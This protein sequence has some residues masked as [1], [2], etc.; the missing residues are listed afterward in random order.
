MAGSAP[1]ALGGPAF[2]PAPWHLQGYGLQLVFLTPMKL[3]RALV[4]AQLEPRAVLPGYSLGA[5]SVGHYDER[6]TLPYNELIVS[7]ALVHAQGSTGLWVSHI[8]VDDE[9]SL[10]GGHA[11]WK[12]D[13][14]RADFS[15]SSDGRT[16]RVASA[17][18]LL[19]EVAQLAAVRVWLPAASVAAFSQR[20]SHLTYFAGRLRSRPSL[21][22]FHF[23][24]GTD[25]PFAASFSRGR[26]LGLRHDDAS[27][28]VNGP[29]WERELAT[30]RAEAAAH[31]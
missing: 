27:L 26:H 22:L 24:V 3:A 15:W 23:D 4:P 18:G 9:R 13:K 17:A 16:V 7:P 30:A 20:G 2:P 10:A 29:I 25:S 8:Y 28:L 19:C 11:I 31:G 12:L 6:G 14:Q 5:V 1:R 21:G